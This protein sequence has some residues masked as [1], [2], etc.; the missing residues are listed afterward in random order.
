MATNFRVKISEMA[1]YSP[2]FVALAFLNGLQYSTY[3]FKT[4]ICHDLAIHGVKIW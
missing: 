3:D 1:H 2:F 4:F